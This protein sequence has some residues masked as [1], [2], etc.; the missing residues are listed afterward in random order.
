VQ[1]PVNIFINKK[2]EIKSTF[3]EMLKIKLLHTFEVLIYNPLNA[4]N[5]EKNVSQICLK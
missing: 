2:I 1:V 5:T 3:Y 4:Q